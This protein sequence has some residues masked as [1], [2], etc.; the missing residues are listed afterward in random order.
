MFTGIVQKTVRVAAVAD[1]PAFRRL[2]LAL[3]DEVQLGE[4]ISVNGVC[5]TVAEILHENAVGFDVIKETLEKTNLGMLT[6]GDEVNIERSLRAGEPISG[7]FVQGHVD[8]VAPLVNQIAGAGETR[9]TLGCP[10]ELVAHLAPKGSVTLDGV[11][12]TIAAVRGS[13]FDVALI[14]S[15]LQLTTMGRKD[16]GY[17]FNLETDVISKT[18]VNYLRQRGI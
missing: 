8:G 5:L 1:G 14:P 17:L 15:T 11:S 13:E 18:V 2:T 3:R 7:H 16:I 10:D 4:S 6:S 12:L 9:L